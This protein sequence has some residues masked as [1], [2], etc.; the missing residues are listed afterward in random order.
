MIICFS[1]IEI[2]SEKRIKE[3]FKR[4]FSRDKFISD[5]YSAF[6]FS[7]D[8]EIQKLIHSLKYEQNYHVGI[9]LGIKT[10]KILYDFN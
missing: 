10:G 7:D 1:Q 4:K 9:F 3:E 5:F 6:V 8:S 2:A